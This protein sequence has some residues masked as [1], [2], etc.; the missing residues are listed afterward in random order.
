MPTNVADFLNPVSAGLGIVEGGIQLVD[1]LGKEKRDRAAIANLERPFYKIQ[2]EYTQNRNLTANA[3]Q[4]GMPAAENDY[5]TSESRR[6]LGAGISGTLQAGGSPNDI[7]K[8]FQSFNNNID[9]TYA[10]SAQQ[11]L[12]NIQYYMEANKDLAGQKNIQF[13]VNELQPYQNKLAQ[14][15]QNANAEQQ[16]AYGGA[17]TAIGSLGALGTSLSNNKLLN[18]LFATPKAAGTDLN[19]ATTADRT[20]IPNYPTPTLQ[21][22]FEPLAT[23]TTNEAPMD[24]SGMESFFNRQIK[25]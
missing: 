23:N 8:L 15:T 25:Y 10:E 16:N 19:T 9:K 21:D 11:H 3:A 13:G 12:K 5:L 6:G 17:N 14:L 4:E 22:P 18:S 7:N 24:L 20:S 2:D 1:S